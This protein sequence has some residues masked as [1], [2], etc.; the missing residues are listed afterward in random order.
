[1]ANEETGVDD[2]N[3]EKP[4]KGRKKG[5]K[6][7][8]VKTLLDAVQNN[9]INESI[10]SGNWI[11]PSIETLNFVR[12]ILKGRNEKIPEKEFSALEAIANGKE[13]IA[14]KKNEQKDIH[15]GKTIEMI[16]K[17]LGT[18][19]A[20]KKT[21]Y[22]IS[23]VQVENLTTANNRRIYLHYYEDKIVINASKERVNWIAETSK[24]K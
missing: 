2:N 12:D 1:M 11:A 14:K 21:P 22:L 6:V 19:S 20:D 24:K 18:R 16:A 3:Q 7:F 15:P 13:A 8:T 17:K 5:V 4:Q 10:E 9:T 23:R